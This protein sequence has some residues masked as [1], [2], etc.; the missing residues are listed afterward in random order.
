MRPRPLLPRALRIFGW[1]GAIGWAVFL[2]VQSGS[3]TIG[4]FLAR[5]LA[6]FPVG[7]DKVGHALAYAVL[8]GFL[9]LATGR[10]WLALLIATLFGV[11]DEIHQHYVQGRVSEVLDVVADATGALVGALAVALLSRLFARR[12]YND[13]RARHRARGDQRA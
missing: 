12:G 5:I 2:V 6:N 8:G 4:G 1:V 11:S 9:S 7:A 10:V 3:P 13:D